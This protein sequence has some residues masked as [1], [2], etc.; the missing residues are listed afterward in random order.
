VSAFSIRPAGPGDGATA[1]RLLDA[2]SAH[3]GDPTGV[4]TAASIERDLCGPDRLARGLLAE[5]G[6]EAVGLAIWLRAWESAVAA[7][8]GFLTDLFVVEGWRGRGV[9]RA[10]MAAVCGAIAAEGGVFLQLTA[11]A[12]NARARAFYDALCGGEDEDLVV[13]TATGERFARLA[14]AGVTSRAGSR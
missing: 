12:R 7:R 11:Q 13:I 14:A 3:E 2:L 6:G 1:A 10:L 5:A 4:L 8:G 9:G